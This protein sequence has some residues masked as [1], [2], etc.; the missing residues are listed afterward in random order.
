MAIIISILYCPVVYLALDQ[1]SLQNRG[2]FVRNPIRQ[3]KFIFLPL[4]RRTNENKYL[5]PAPGHQGFQQKW[6]TSFPHKASFFE[7][8][9]TIFVTD[10]STNAKLVYWYLD[11]R[12]L[13]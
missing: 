4:S 9:P 13:G 5:D 11:G 12:E 7:D 1:F 2:K 10:S 8:I 6:K 3:S